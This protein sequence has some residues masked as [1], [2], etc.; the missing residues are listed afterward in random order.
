MSHKSQKKVI[1]VAN[2]KVAEALIHLLTKHKNIRCG[3]ILM[4]LSQP[5]YYKNIDGGM[6]KASNSEILEVVKLIRDDFSK[7]NEKFGDNWFD[8]ED[9]IEES[10][11]HDN[12]EDDEEDDF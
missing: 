5:K 12:Y 6:Y 10:R 7:M 8:E 4:A 3:V 2:N 1:D 11:F 9:E